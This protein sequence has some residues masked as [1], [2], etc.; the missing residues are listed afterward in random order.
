MRRTGLTL[1]ALLAVLAAA[2]IASRQVIVMDMPGESHRGALARLSPA[3]AALAKRLESDV[4]ALA[5]EIGERNLFRHGSLERAVRHI[6]QRF[7]A[8]GHEAAFQ[9]FAVR[10]SNVRNVEVVI[11]GRDPAAG[12]V[13][14]GAHYDSVQGSPGAN[15]NASGVAALL[16]LGR[17]LEGSALKRGI[18]LVA[19]VN[20]EAP[21]TYTES[22]GSVR[23][24]EHLMER[25][26]MVAA[27]LSLETIG[28]YTDEPGTQRYPFPLSY[29][30][31]DTGNFIG[32][33]GNPASKALVRRVVRTF[34]E[35][36]GFPSEGLAAPERIRGV[37][38]S[39][40]WSFWQ[41]GWPAVM[42]TDTALYRYHQYHTAEDTPRILVYDR[43]ARVVEGLVAVVVDLAGIDERV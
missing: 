34:R 40:H 32:F 2:V 15:D 17:A 35:N 12:I 24:A 23:Y 29:F 25:G 21:F 22:M 5:G 41:L 6:A 26:E 14:V 1:I 39:D 13:V 43:F 30:Y 27:M 42:V 33:V 3:Q 36:A 20:E 31:P 16:E 7:R 9:E 19:F 28:Y 8:A 11:P 38:W 18:R 37:G 10:G 4:T